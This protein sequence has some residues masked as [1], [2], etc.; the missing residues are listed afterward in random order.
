MRKTWFLF[1]RVYIQK[2]EC[3]AKK[4][5]TENERQ[6]LHPTVIQ[7]IKKRSLLCAEKMVRREGVTLH[8][9]AGAEKDTL[10][11]LS[12]FLHQICFLP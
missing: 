2:G 1:T 5:N 10:P 12:T 6:T 8:W 11:A 7:A 4:K 3:H 9:D